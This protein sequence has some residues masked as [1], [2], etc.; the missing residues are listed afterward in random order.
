MLIKDP[1][2]REALLRALADEQSRQILASTRHRPR[3]AM[4]LVRE[5]DL[6]SSSAYRRIHELEEDGLLA[7]AKTILTADGK[8]YQLYK[9][10]FREVNVKFQGGEVLVIAEPNL[11]MVQKAFRLFHSFREEI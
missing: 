3:S 1:P 6:P 11:D 9:A 5:E 7:V 2:L 8:K 10:T 4:D